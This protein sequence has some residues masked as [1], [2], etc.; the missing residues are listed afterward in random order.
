MR[1]TYLIADLWGEIS[2]EPWFHALRASYEVSYLWDRLVDHSGTTILDDDILSFGAVSGSVDHER[3]VRA[4]ARLSRVTRIG[5]AES[6]IELTSRAKIGEMLVRTALPDGRPDTG[7]V[8]IVMP[9]DEV[10]FPDYAN[11]RRE[12]QAAL[13]LYCLSFKSKYQALV[14]VV[15]VA[16]DSTI[17]PNQRVYYLL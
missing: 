8:L 16:L 12:R 13:R 2:S 15:G 4:L 10:Q 5:L 7:V 6:L 17:L 14:H 1:S 9:Y 3:R 11:Y